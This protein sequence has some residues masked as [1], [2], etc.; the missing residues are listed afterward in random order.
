MNTIL[1]FAL[2]FAGEISETPAVG[3][4]TPKSFGKYQLKYLATRTPMTLVA[5]NGNTF[6]VKSLPVTA[7]KL[8]LMTRT[9]QSV[10]VG[11]I[12][13]IEK[14]PFVFK[15]TFRVV[16]SGETVWILN[17]VEWR[18]FLSLEPVPSFPWLTN[19]ELQN[20]KWICLFFIL[21]G[22]ICYKFK[23]YLLIGIPP[24]LIVLA[25][26]D[27]ILVSVWMYILIAILCGA[28]GF[29]RRRKKV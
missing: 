14:I 13:S 22:W 11:E 5:S 23:E 18:R 16:R 29:Y 7:T 9:E 1:L 28:I 15:E 26:V 21:G 24:V 4:E 20:W 17:D 3:A 10:D 19:G 2:V 25:K 8:V 6:R 12:D 27:Y